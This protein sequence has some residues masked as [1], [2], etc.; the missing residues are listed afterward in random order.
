MRIRRLTQAITPYLLMLP[1]CLLLSVFLYGVGNGIAQGFGIMPFLG[2]TTPTL[3]YYAEALTNPDL[4]TSL[5]YSL[6]LSLISSVIAIVG[7]VAL[8]ALLIAR[9]AH[10]LT[11]T[12]V[13]QI[14]LMCAHALVAACV[15]SLF[16]GS[17]LF[18]RI[19]FHA[20]LISGPESFPSVIGATSG[21]GIIL[22]YVWKEIPFV[23]FSTITVMRH[24]STTFG[25]AA[26]TLGAS[27]LRTFF[28][29]TLPLCHGAILKAFLIIFAFS[30]G[31]YEVP[32][33][34]GPTLPKALPVLTY[35][36]FC[37]PDILNRCYAMALNGIIAGICSLIA[38]IYF[39]VL[40]REHHT[41]EGTAHE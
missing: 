31:A 18:A 28:T 41:G 11:Q 26:A 7:G 4:L 3:A 10:S 12:I 21:W 20:G 15:V 38:L 35:L 5:G 16:A 17:G 24:L 9:K 36:E 1:A 13:I 8:C 37:D 40:L 2:K 25:D 22:V 33:L 27:P 19:L 29:V 23:A 30:F 14:P 6:Y 32:F 39:A 34:L